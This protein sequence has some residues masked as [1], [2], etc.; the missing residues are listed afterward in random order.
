MDGV[1]EKGKLLDITCKILS[2]FMKEKIC[3]FLKIQNLRVSA[4]EEHTDLWE[5][6]AGDILAICLFPLAMFWVCYGLG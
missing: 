6:K 3:A 5:G 1:L 4:K 2:I